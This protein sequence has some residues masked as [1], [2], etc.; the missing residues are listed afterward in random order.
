MTLLW[1]VF[2]V[3]LFAG[4]AA[5]DLSLDRFDELLGNDWFGIYTR[6]SKIGYASIGLARV[7]EARWLMNSDLVF[8]Y[9][10]NQKTLTITSSEE[11]TYE[12]L[13]AELVSSKYEN[14]TNTG[15]ISVEGKKVNDEYIVATIIADQTTEEK[16]NFPLETLDNVLSVEIAAISGRLKDKSCFKSKTFISDP[17]LTGMAERF[18]TVIERR[19]MIINGVETDVFTV[20]DS[21]ASLMMGANIILDEFGNHMR[22][23]IPS[24]GIIMKSEPKEMA[25]KIEPGFDLLT[26]NLII[27]PNGPEHPGQITKGTYLISGYQIDRLPESE[28]V[29]IN[30]ITRD[31]AEITITLP[32]NKV[33]N[34]IIGVNTGELGEYL[35]SESLIQSNNQ[36]IIDLAE[37]IIGDETNAYKATQLIN[38]WVYS[39]IK[40][41]FSPDI[42][43]AFQTY[44][45]GRG[46][47]GEHS[48]LATA[49]LRAVGIPSRIAAGVV[50]WPD[51]GGF[52]FHAWVEAYVGEWIQIEPTLN[53]ELANA[54]HIMLARGGLKD[55]LIALTS[56]LKNVNII[57]VSYE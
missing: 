22:L 20:R 21:T 54:T 57:I 8:T 27:V 3:I 29:D 16:F 15:N 41:E 34:Q 39:N 5:A 55:H 43:N 44:K 10:V 45:S 40:K 47:C 17:P 13:N 51:G 42:S 4:S 14:L 6:D 48:A 24:M 9:T 50:Y 36:E 25:Q 1:I 46:D 52:S 19:Q 31:S 7:S 30:E 35:K 2:F 23:E 26:D 12:G 32:V 11:K 49:L 38:S 53:E 37:S 56:A 33:Y 28:W 18:K